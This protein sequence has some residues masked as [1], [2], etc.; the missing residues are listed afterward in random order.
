M[1]PSYTHFMIERGKL[2][3]GL[4]FDESAAAYA[5]DFVEGGAFRQF[6][7]DSLSAADFVN[8]L[9]LT[10]GLLDSTFDAQR[11]SA[12]V[13]LSQG[14]KTRAQVL[15]DVIEIPEF[16]TREYNPAFVLMQYYGYLRR[17]PDPGGYQF[18]L[19]VLNTKLPNDATGY[20]SMVC[21]FI[22]SGEYQDRFSP[23]RTRADSECIQ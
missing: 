20:R 9:F 1:I 13:D 2:S 8:K 23:I 10:A 3:G 6:Y 14:R 22:T 11:Q 15:M 21:A 17:D 19:N 5:R 16:R 7:P 12:I 18:W 4:T